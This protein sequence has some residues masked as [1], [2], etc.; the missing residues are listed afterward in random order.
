MI[1]LY[2][3]G[4]LRVP[5]D[6]NP[7]EILLSYKADAITAHAEVSRQSFTIPAGRRGMIGGIVLEVEA[8][9]VFTGSA[10]GVIRVAR[11]PAVDNSTIAVV[12][13]RGLA[14]KDKG[15]L[16]VNA[17]A[18]LTAGEVVDI[19]TILTPGTG[20]ADFRA[21]VNLLTYDA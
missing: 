16:A 4:N 18:L 1:I 17:E 7:L 3:G 8:T 15:S 6:R 12:Q 21:T 19:R 11:N 14:A 13:T 9:V 20:T 10:L 2:P 5:I